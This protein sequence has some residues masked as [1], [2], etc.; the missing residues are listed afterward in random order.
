MKD[1]NSIIITSLLMQYK[2]LYTEFMNLYKYEY[3]YEI[4]AVLD[5]LAMLLF[6]DLNTF[7]FPSIKFCWQ[8]FCVVVLKI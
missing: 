4:F 5:N 3:F 2:A 7:N 1:F 8:T 6:Q